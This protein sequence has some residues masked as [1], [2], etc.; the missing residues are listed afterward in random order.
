VCF[1]AFGVNVSFIVPLSYEFRLYTVNPT[2]KIG[3]FDWGFGK[4]IETVKDIILG[5]FR[6]VFDVTHRKKE[7]E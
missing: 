1:L 2:A 5:L 3:R 4:S 7:K 6:K